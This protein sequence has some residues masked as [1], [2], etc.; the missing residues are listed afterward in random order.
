[1]Q[2]FNDGISRDRDAS[3]MVA[4]ADACQQ[5]NNNLKRDT[6]TRS[7]DKKQR[8][9]IQNENKRDQNDQGYNSERTILLDAMPGP[10]FPK[11]STSQRP[12]TPQH[13]RNDSTG[14]FTP[15]FI[16]ALGLNARPTDAAR[17]LAEFS[18]KRWVWLKDDKLA[19]VKGW[20]T[21]DKGSVL[22]VK[23]DNETVDRIV[24]SQ[25][26]DKVNPPKFNLADDMADLTYLNEA[27]VIHNLRQRYEADLIYVHLFI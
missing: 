21:Q 18:G 8:R 13:V 15:K 11:Q 20:V 6:K 4:V 16:N 14:T 10:V 27:S 22:Q 19:F 3:E 26:V 9:R 12:S 7:N 2:K 24:D 25:A 5:I 17:D 23:C 1:M